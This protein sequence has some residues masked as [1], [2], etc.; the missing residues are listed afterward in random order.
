MLSPVKSQEIPAL[1]AGGL[2][3]IAPI[4]PIEVQHICWYICWYRLATR[5]CRYQHAHGYSDQVRQ[6]R[7]ADRE[8]FR[9]GGLQLWITPQGGKYWRLAYRFGGKQRVLAIGVYP[10]ISL[11]DARIA[12][13][14]AKK[15]LA[16]GQDPSRRRS[17]T[18]S[19]QRR[20]R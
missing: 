18:G 7:Q 10:A 12:R 20:S 17:W 9:R 11:K 19:R 15:V 16:A 4:R 6:A 13:D 3:R 5:W 8:A 1:C 2:S 14:E